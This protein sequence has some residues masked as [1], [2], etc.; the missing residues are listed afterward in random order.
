MIN[1]VRAVWRLLGISIYDDEVR[2]KQNL[3]TISALSVIMLIPSSFGGIIYI[4]APFPLR[5]FALGCF[6]YS[7]LHI[8][9]FY[10]AAIK[11]DRKLTAVLSTTLALI[12]CVN[13]AVF[14]K[15]GFAAHWTLLFRLLYVISAVYV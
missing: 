14:A 2:C 5:G 9:I 6:V 7:L 13:I 8:L 15:N 3:K 12:A 1:R 10:L 4:S 11:K